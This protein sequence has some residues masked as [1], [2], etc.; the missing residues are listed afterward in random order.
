[1]IMEIIDKI[2]SIIDYILDKYLNYPIYY[3]KI[4]HGEIFI[5]SS[6]NKDIPLIIVKCENLEE[7]PN[8][9]IIYSH[10]N[11]ENILNSI[12]Y[13]QF[14]ANIIGVDVILYDYIGYGLSRE[15]PSENDSYDSLKS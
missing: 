13:W 11:N 15:N 9:C 2:I 6:Y 12:N 5:K 1:M 7:I 3:T 8:K 10:G 4:D 14:H